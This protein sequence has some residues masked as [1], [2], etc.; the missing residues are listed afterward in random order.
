M[1]FRTG[2][3]THEVPLC[4]CHQQT[5]LPTDRVKTCSAAVLR[6]GIQETEAQVVVAIARVVPVPISRPH[7]AGVAVPAAAPDHAV[8]ALRLRPAQMLTSC[9]PNRKSVC[10]LDCSR[11]VPQI[12][13]GSDTASTVNSRIDTSASSMPFASPLFSI[14][15][16]CNRICT[17]IICL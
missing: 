6:G 3:L 17:G 11:I 9:I 13:D 12:R 14:C 8:G 1:C 7:V 4:V 2:L 15:V 5:I 16:L 10:A